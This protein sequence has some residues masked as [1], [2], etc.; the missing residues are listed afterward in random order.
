MSPS[1]IEVF[2]DILVRVYNT[3]LKGSDRVSIDGLYVPEEDNVELGEI[4]FFEFMPDTAGEFTIKY[5]NSKATGT[6]VVQ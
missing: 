5:L 3:S 1:R 6:L 2:K 4:T